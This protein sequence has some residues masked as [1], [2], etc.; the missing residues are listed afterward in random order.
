MGTVC[1]TLDFAAIRAAV[2][3]TRYVTGDVGEPG[4][5]GRWQC[6]LHDGEGL[7]FSVKGDR[8][9][10]FSSCGS[11]DIFDYAARRQNITR[12][13][14]ARHLLA[15]TGAAPCPSARKPARKAP[16]PPS[17][18]PEADALALVLDAEKRLWT[19]EGEAALDYLTADGA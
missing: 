8:W 3:L 17:G 2:D 19:A 10:C 13:E 15:G 16:A 1:N 4:R 12:V 6:P 9:K 11:G 7:N 18:M 14:A 5:G